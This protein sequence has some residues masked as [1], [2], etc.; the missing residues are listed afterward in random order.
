[1]ISR[2]LRPRS[3]LM[4]LLFLS[5]PLILISSS[6]YGYL[7]SNN[8]SDPYPMFQSQDPHYFMDM[9]RRVE[10]KDANYALC[11][12]ECYSLSLSP[13]AQNA[14]VGRNYDGLA[15]LPEN[16]LPDPNF[17]N[18]TQAGVEMCGPPPCVRV[19]IE[20]GDL[21]GRV[22]MLALITGAIPIGQ[23]LSPALQEAFT[24][25]FPSGVVEQPLS[26]LSDPNQLYASFT[27]PIKHRKRGFRIDFRG[28]IT[29]QIGFIIETGVASISRSFE[30]VDLTCSA[31]S[32]CMFILP[33]AEF[34]SSVNEYLMSNF[35]TIADELNINICDGNRL[36]WEEVRL[37]LFW[38]DTYEMNARD[39]Y[40]ELYPH[41]LFMP[42]A[43]LGG[44]VSP[45]KK[46]HPG[47]IFGAPFGNDGHASFGGT[48]GLDFDFADTIEISAEVGITQFFG[49]T[50]CR[51]VPTSKYQRTLFP[52][53]TPVHYTPGLNWHFCGKMAA[54][55]FLDNLSFY[56]QYVMLEHK[57]DSIK[58][59]TPDPA[60]Q[61][62]VQECR[63]AFKAK[64]INTAFN[65][66]LSPN[67]SVGLLW[68]IP[69]GQRNT[70]K[71]TTILFSFNATF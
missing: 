15:F 10:W 58:L 23:Q 13:F 62:K 34:T 19:P 20:L 67:T 11:K 48:I 37:Y 9:V 47:D 5:I 6:A 70:Y 32:S 57:R 17:F 49:R 3:Q 42:F 46:L 55:H 41:Y 12:K 53:F 44:S 39:C 52:F 31:T 71:S 50:E 22:D 61:P 21:E 30:F 4:P 29:D 28:M 54:Y 27:V 36:S 51:G 35:E 1:M 63:S 68:Q 56:F 38:R 65:Y 66:D 69:I 2:L 43:M 18:P 24:A 60:F 16:T 8:R 14:E 40:A 25:L 45:G 64:L 7:T 59:V 33:D 26:Q